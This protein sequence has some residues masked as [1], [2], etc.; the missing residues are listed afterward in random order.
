MSRA[1]AQSQGY[2]R[3]TQGVLKG[4]SSTRTRLSPRARREAALKCFGVTRDA[5]INSRVR[6]TAPWEA[7]TGGALLSGD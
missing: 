2:S 6:T 7:L 4:Y 3:G 1:R 5:P